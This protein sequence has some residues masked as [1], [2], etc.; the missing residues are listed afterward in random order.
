MPPSLA[1]PALEPPA[2]LPAVAPPWTLS[3]SS[4]IFPH[5]TSPS[6]ISSQRSASCSAAASSASSLAQRQ[7]LDAG[8]YAPREVLYSG[9]EADVF[10]GGLGGWIIYRYTSSPVGPYDEL[11][12]VAGSFA[13]AETGLTSALDTR[14]GRQ[15][16]LWGPNK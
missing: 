8:S 12:H 13:S 4:W 10:K 3:A 9:A 1:P 14:C 15:H 2:G 6:H 16:T 5:W 11:I 7:G